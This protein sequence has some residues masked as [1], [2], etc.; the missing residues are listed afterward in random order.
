MKRKVDLGDRE[1]VLVGTKH[2]SKDSVEEVETVIEEEQP[3]IVGVELDEN[4][5]ASLEGKTKWKD[6]DLLEAIK[7]GQ[8]YLLAANLFLMIYQKK[9]GVKEGVK[10]GQELLNAVEVARNKDIDVELLDRDINDTF[11]RAY[12]NLTFWEKIKLLAGLVPGGNE[13]VQEIS[14]EQDILDALVE[15]L[16]DEF[17]TISQVF[18]EERNHIMADR[19]LEEEFDKAVMVV[20]AAHI[21]GTVEHLKNHTPYQE[22]DIKK[23][24]LL[25]YLKYG[26]SLGIIGLLSLGFMRGG[27]EQLIELGVIWVAVNCIMSGLGAI[28]ARSHPKTWITSVTVAPFTSMVPLIG[29]GMVAAY[30]E[31]RFHP[32]TVEELEAMTEI[33]TYQELM[34]NQVGVIL[35]TLVLV[36]I[37]G[38]FATILGGALLTLAVLFF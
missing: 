15:E 30:V 22:K 25:K 32:P 33:S 4:R 6:I 36:S 10:P 31:A 8:G 18:L 26:F 29:A 9:L 38:G 16:E 2:V 3:D 5:L 12:N 7:Q 17:P 19:M 1:V 11:R 13:G 27:V 20:G 28:L 35:A 24:N 14:L 37:L 21:K 34:D 23:T